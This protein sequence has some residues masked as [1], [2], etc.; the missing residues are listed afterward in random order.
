M[1][2]Y[3]IRQWVPSV[4]IEEQKHQFIL[5][6]EMAGVDPKN[7]QIQMEDGALTI[8]GEKV[9]ENRQEENNYKRVERQSGKFYRCFLLP[10]GTADQSIKA[11]SKHSVLEITIPKIKKQQS[12]TISIEEAE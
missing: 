2:L 12:K 9:I 8:K 6:A 5:K 11:R 4:D 3:T 10:D 7:I 1:F